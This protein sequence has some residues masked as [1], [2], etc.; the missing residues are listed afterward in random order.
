MIRIVAGELR[1]RR[2]AVAPGVRPTTER[3]REALF[4]ILGERVRGARVLDAAAGS[5]ALGFEALSR[6]AREIVFV[7]ADRRTA[8]VLEANA[9]G[10]RLSER[11]RVFVRPVATFLRIDRPSGF[12]LVFFDP[13]WADPVA[14]ELDG[15]W[16]ALS[17]GGTFVVERGSAENPWPGSPVESEIRRYGTTVLHIFQRADAGPADPAGTASGPASFPDSLLRV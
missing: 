10:V 4:S 6:G 12:D 15:L 13:P 9:L 2:L 8:A 11:V 3:A 5:G 7:E 16:A 17:P 14:S 1:G